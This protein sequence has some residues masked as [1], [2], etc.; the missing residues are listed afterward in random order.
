MPVRIGRTI[1]AALVIVLIFLWWSTNGIAGVFVYE[2]SV[3]LGWQANPEPDI[4][5]YEVYRSNSYAG[6]YSKAHAGLI[7]QTHWT[8]TNLTLG[9]T[10]YYKLRAVD[11]CGNAGL[12]SPPSAAVRYSDGDFDDDGFGDDFEESLGTSAVE[13]NSQPAA[14][15]LTL[16]SPKTTFSIGGRCQLDV[17]GDF[18][19]VVGD[20]IP[21]DMTCLVQY[22]FSPAGSVSISSCGRVTGQSPAVVTIWAEQL[23]GGESVAVSNTV[24]VTVTAPVIHYVPDDFATI[25]AALDA[26][27]NGDSIIVRDGVYSGPGN[28]DID[29]TGKVVTLRSQNG[30]ANC[31]IDG[32]GTARLFTFHSGEG[33][34][35]VVD[36]FTI[37]GGSSSSSGGAIFCK[38][39]SPTITN[40]IMTNNH[41]TSYGGAIYLGN[42]ASAT[43]INN[44]ISENSTDANGGAIYCWYSSPSIMNCTIT[45]NEA[46]YGGGMGGSNSVPV[47]SNSIFWNN[48][49]NEIGGSATVTSSD[50]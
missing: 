1:T 13:G 10:Y 38:S 6:T 15:S 5:G 31:I 24:Q 35:A 2:P 43:L 30:A 48:F 39:S 49:P 25:Q 45:A 46:N 22:R 4:Q 41:A 20:P 37:T 44:I 42:G 27:A 28:T 33:S 8:D 17:A 19:P 3:A 26:A 50:V 9:G 36:G 7:N 14:A 32:Q 16:T 34:G 47:I 18:Q 29:F 12:F 23:I 40:C 11:F 21:Y